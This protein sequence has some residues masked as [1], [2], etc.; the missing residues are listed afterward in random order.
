MDRDEAAK[1]VRVARV[2]ERAEAV[3]ED[4]ES[5]RRWLKTPNAA[6]AGE[7]PISL[8]DTSKG[9]ESVLDILVRIEYGGVV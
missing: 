3:F 1:L 6:L 7:T 2:I 5:A 8:L 9:I 4:P